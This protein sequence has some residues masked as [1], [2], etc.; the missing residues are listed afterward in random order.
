MRGSE[1]ADKYLFPLGAI[2]GRAAPASIGFCREMA[3]MTVTLA[4]LVVA[5]ERLEDH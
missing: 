1:F 2:I 5:M 3:R 4:R